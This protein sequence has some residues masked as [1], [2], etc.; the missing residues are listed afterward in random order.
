VRCITALLKNYFN[1]K[2]LSEHYEFAPSGKYH[3]PKDLDLA[4]VKKYIGQLPLDDEPE[5]FGLHPNANI[6]F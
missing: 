6:T 2:V 1:D 3:A 5:V 4:N